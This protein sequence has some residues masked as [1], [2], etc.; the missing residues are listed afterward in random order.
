MVS[1]NLLNVVKIRK[2]L[3]ELGGLTKLLITSL[4]LLRFGRDKLQNE[5]NSK[6]YN[7]TSKTQRISER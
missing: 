1:E 4:I 7:I 2:L 3:A 5:Q 6:G